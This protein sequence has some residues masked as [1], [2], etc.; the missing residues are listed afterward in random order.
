MKMKRKMFTLLLAIVMVLSC[1]PAPAMAVSEAPTDSEPIESAFTDATFLATVRELVGKTNGEHIYQSDVENITEL[2]IYSLGIASLDGIEFFT[3]LTDLICYDNALIT[4]DLS[5][6]PNLEVLDCSYCEYLTSI[7]VSNCPELS[8]LDCND[9][10][11]QRLDVRQNTKL[12]SLICYETPLRTLNISNNP[13]LETLE[14][15]GGHLVNL[16]VSNNSALEYLDCSYNF[17]ASVESVMGLENCTALVEDAFSFYPQDTSA[18]T[19]SFTDE[20]FLSAVRKTIEKPSGDI[21]PEDLAEITELVVNNSG[22]TSLDGIEYM[23]SLETLDCTSNYLDELDLYSNKE[24]TSVQCGDNDL[25]ELDLSGN[26]KLVSVS[27]ANN[28]LTSFN[29]SNS[30]ALER[31]NVSY[32]ELTELDLSSNDSLKIL[33]CSENSIADIEDIRL[34][35]SIYS[36]ISSSVSTSFAPV[37]SNGFTIEFLP[38]APA[39]FEINLFTS[40]IDKLLVS[41]K[42]TRNSTISIYDIT[43]CDLSEIPEKYLNNSEKMDPAKPDQAAIVNRL[44]EDGIHIGEVDSPNQTFSGELYLG[45]N[46]RVE[47]KFLAIHSRRIGQDAARIVTVPSTLPYVESF[48]VYNGRA[49]MELI[50]ND[51]PLVTTYGSATFTVKL[52]NAENINKLYLNIHRDYRNKNYTMELK[53][54]PNGIYQGSIYLK[55]GETYGSVGY[56]NSLATF[57]IQATYVSEGAGTTKQ[58]F[59]SKPV[60]LVIDPSGYIYEG[61]PSNRLT[62]V[63]TT[64]YYMDRDGNT[65]E[66]NASEYEQSN[67]IFSDRNGRYEWFVPDGLWQVKAECDGYETFYTDWVRVPPAQ[68]DMNFGM[69]SKESPVIEQLCAYPDAVEINLTKYVYADDITAESVVVYANNQQLQGT[70]R[71]VDAEIDHWDG[72]YNTEASGGSGNRYV[73]KLRFFPND[74]LPLGTNIKVCLNDNIR[75][76][77]NVT[78]ASNYSQETLVRVRPTRMSAGSNSDIMGAGS[79]KKIYYGERVKMSVSILPVE[80]SQG[81]KLILTNEN[82]FVVSVPSEVIVGEDGIAEIPMIGLALGETHIIATLEGSNLSAT[83]DVEVD[84][85]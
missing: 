3:A 14:A 48:K 61:V 69:V 24:L 13:L 49:S 17:M 34:P 39:L 1:I 71:L 2:N 4:L 74:E 37:T 16:D 44:S 56:N 67:P 83:Y 65:V 6:N 85:R 80:A 41:G 73:S 53:K 70:V 62:D 9:T 12:T 21:Y 27:V 28:K 79:S 46:R 51:Y 57:T 38:Q 31:V 77:A 60:R 84:L 42:G 81:Q 52:G 35:E 64:L 75:S 22:L 19:E 18:V 55:G 66:W 10:E 54:L 29:V 20:D 72:Q 58:D 63:K 78:V 43:D 45:T 76:Y 50:G 23:S 5:H 11:L 15:W 47:Y 33:L 82:P 8:S 32:N 25:T 26:E 36:Q 30:P 59:Y 68:M 7:D 40:G